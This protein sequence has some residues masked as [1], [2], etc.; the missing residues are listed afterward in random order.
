MGFSPYLNLD[1]VRGNTIGFLHMAGVQII[2]PALS[3]NYFPV[4]KVYRFIIFSLPIKSGI[5]LLNCLVLIFYLYIHF[6]S[7]RCYYVHP[8]GGWTYYFCFFSGVRCPD[9]WVPLICR[10]SIYPI[11]TKFGNFRPTGYLRNVLLAIF[12]KFSCS[13]LW[14]PF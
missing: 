1:T 10:K 12:K 11:F 14:R 6:L 3:Y 8:T 13:H 5:L 4:N 7:H 2:I 9:A